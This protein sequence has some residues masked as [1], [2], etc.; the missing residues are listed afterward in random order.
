[1]LPARNAP[2][3]LPWAANLAPH[4]KP[5]DLSKGSYQGY[6]IGNGAE[7]PDQYRI[8]C[9]RSFLEPIAWAFGVTL[10]QHRRPPVLKLEHVRFPVRM[11][12]VAWRGQKDR[13][14]ARQG[15]MEGPVLGMQCRSD[16][17]YGATGKT[18]AKS[19]LDTVRE[20]GG[21]LLLA[22]ER[23]REG[24]TERRGGE[25][26]WWT[27]KERWGGKPGGEAGDAEGASDIP[28]K[29]AS[30]QAPEKYV[31]RNFDGSKA[32]R[33]PT[34]AEVWKTL[35][36]GQPLW[37]PKVV[38]EA[39]GKNRSVDWDDVCCQT[40]LRNVPSLLISSVGLHGVVIEPP[41]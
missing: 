12:S 34:P 7:M 35:K 28:V 24:K 29:E 6:R 5:V 2:P 15:W 9:I 26:S 8:D 21:L 17:N 41:H 39:I 10:A 33:R 23:A 19:V 18:D 32:R 22:Q 27:T 31:Q 11:T 30:V 16:V 20:L 40:L 14:N 38:Y 36:P 25:G 1:M 13:V 4:D 37:D 3:K